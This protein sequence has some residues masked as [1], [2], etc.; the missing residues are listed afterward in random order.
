MMTCRELADFLMTYLDG[1]LPLRQKAVFEIHLR[2]CPGC[3]HYLESYKETIALG[4]SICKEPD[5]PVPQDVPEELVQ[6]IMA[7]RRE[8]G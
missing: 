2:M 4:K 3:K 8:G 5:G 6:A 7:A 1:E